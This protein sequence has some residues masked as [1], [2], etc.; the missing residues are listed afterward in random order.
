MRS[1]ILFLFSFL[2]VFML[3]FT[4]CTASPQASTTVTPTL[5]PSAVVGEDQCTSEALSSLLA[6][7]DA[8]VQEFEDVLSLAMMSKQDSLITLVLRLQ[9]VRRNVE[10]LEMPACAATLQTDLVNYMNER[11]SYLTNA[12]KSSAIAEEDI[13][14]GDD[15]QNVY[16]QERARLSGEA[17]NPIPT[18][19]PQPTQVVV[20]ATNSSGADLPIYALPAFD[21]TVLGTLSAGGQVQVIAH[22]SDYAWLVIVISQTQGGFIEASKVTVQGAIDQLPNYEDIVTNK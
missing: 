13:Q 9:D 3:L 21:A 7:V 14:K 20:L 6:D 5:Q 11:I 8:Q 2:T 16:L 17:F 19:T 15:L 1:K 12:I 18:S 10:R 22:T 4:G